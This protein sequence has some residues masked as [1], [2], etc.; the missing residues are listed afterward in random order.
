VDYG[1]SK[2]S[3]K[4]FLPLE[5]GGDPFWNE[6]RVFS[7]WEAWGYLFSVAARYGEQPWVLR[8]GQL[9]TLERGETKPLSVRYLEQR[10]KW[11]KNKV[12][13]FLSTLSDMDRI[14][15]HQRTAD[16]DTY[17]VV[18]YNLYQGDRDSSGTDNGTAAGQRRDSGGT[19]EKQ[20]KQEKQ[21]KDGTL[22]G[23]VAASGNGRASSRSW[24]WEAWQEEFSDEL[25]GL[26]YTEARRQKFK[27]FHKEHLTDRPDAKEAFRSMLKGLREHEFW[28]DKP[29]TWKPE[30][31]MKNAERREDVALGQRASGGSSGR[32]LDVHLDPEFYT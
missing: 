15:V 16:G 23:S 24:M 18:N 19:K 30:V 26:S 25:P 14:A 6:P 12:H 2:V 9:I 7:R 28:G 31:C 21:V 3:R 20:V 29:N 17:L 5:Q 13:R 10:W 22:S 11:G 1:H 4:A 8:G 32:G 27:S